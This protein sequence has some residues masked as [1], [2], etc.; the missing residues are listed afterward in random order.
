MKWQKTGIKAIKYKFEFGAAFVI[1][2]ITQKHT[3][4]KIFHIMNAKKV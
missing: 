1:G 4:T 2:K 3:H